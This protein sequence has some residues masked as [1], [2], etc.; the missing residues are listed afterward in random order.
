[1]NFRILKDVL[2][3]IKGPETNPVLHSFNKL[4]KLQQQQEEINKIQT[5]DQILQLIEN[6]KKKIAILEKENEMYSKK[7]YSIS[8]I[9]GLLVI[10][11]Q[12][13]QYNVFHYRNKKYKD[14][15]QQMTNLT[16][17]LREQLAKKPKLS[18]P[19]TRRPLT[20]EMK[21]NIEEF[22]KSQEQLENKKIENNFYNETQDSKLY[23][24]L[25]EVKDLYYVCANQGLDVSNFDQASFISRILRV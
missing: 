19:A 10:K 5:K 16:N 1:M 11:P 18:V 23:S 3:D 20:Q 12:K 8:E 21:D 7:I 2:H 25:D 24:L 6:E 14:L 15:S 9:N 17:E 22:I 13:S 4:Y